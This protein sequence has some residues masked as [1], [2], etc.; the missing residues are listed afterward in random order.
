M[1][2]DKIENIEKYSLCLPCQREGDRE[3]V[4]GFSAKV[5]DFLINLTPET[6]AGRYEIADGIY[7]N[8]DEY[9]PKNYE[10][11]KFEAH[12]KYIDIQMVLSG[13]ENLEYRCAD[14]LKISE[15]YDEK[16]DIMFF[17]NPEEKSD[18]VHLTPFKFALIYPH[19]AH[20]P[21][22]KTV[23]SFVKKV[24]VKIKVNQ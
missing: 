4:E 2:I 17:E 21:Q 9:E 24:V 16:R 19:E 7:A 18:Y 3:A 10:N 6:P 11:C 12:K 1:I 23:S 5:I 13:E 15:E 8:V 22:I 20:K 14:G